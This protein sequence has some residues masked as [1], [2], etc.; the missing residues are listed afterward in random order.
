MLRITWC[1]ENASCVT[2]KVEG[3]IVSDWVSLLDQECK[4]LVEPG[5]KVLLDFSEVRY[6]DCRGIEMLKR[7]PS[8]HIRII[9]CP[10][11]IEDLLVPGDL[12]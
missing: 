9:N 4:A 3:W 7:L 10:T 12:P 11:L 2:L 8:E 1:R 5:R 6:V